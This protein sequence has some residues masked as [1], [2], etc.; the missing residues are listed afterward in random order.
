[1]MDVVFLLAIAAFFALANS[2]VHFTEKLGEKPPV[3]TD[4]KTPH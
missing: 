2:Y 1:M 4:M 3:R